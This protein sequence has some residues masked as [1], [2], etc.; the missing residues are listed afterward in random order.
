[1]LETAQFSTVFPKMSFEY[2]IWNGIS[3]VEQFW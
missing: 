3:E 2:P 1:M